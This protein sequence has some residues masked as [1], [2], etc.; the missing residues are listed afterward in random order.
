MGRYDDIK[1]ERENERSYEYISEKMSGRNSFTISPS[2]INVIFFSGSCK[3]LS[4]SY[5]G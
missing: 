2:L 3:Y 5:I 4:P 1:K